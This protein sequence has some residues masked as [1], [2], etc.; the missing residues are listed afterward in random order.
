MKTKTIALMTCATIV[1]AGCNGSGGSTTTTTTTSPTYD[2][3]FRDGVKTNYSELATTKGIESYIGNPDGTISQVK[4]RASSDYT[5]LF[6]SMDG[7]AEV[8]YTGTGG[9][10]DGSTFITRVWTAAN[11]DKFRIATGTGDTS[12]YLRF[13]DNATGLFSRGVGGLETAI[14]DLPTN[15]SYSGFHS[16]EGAGVTSSGNIALSVDFANGTLDGSINNANFFDGSADNTYSAD[17]TGTT[18]G[19]RIAAT[20]TATGTVTGTLDL[21]GAAQGPNASELNGGIA[22]SLD[23]GGGAQTLGGYFNLLKQ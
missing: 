4:V 16:A 17:I 5:T 12:A 14:N 21:A 22:G 18:N 23:S 8:E 13:E 10:T 7:S 3:N 6:V 11:G 15:A 9:T 1:L 20:A 2:A 19:G